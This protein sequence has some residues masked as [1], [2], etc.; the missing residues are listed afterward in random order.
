MKKFNIKKNKNNW[1]KNK[2]YENLNNNVINLININLKNLRDINNASNIFI[3]NSFKVGL[4][5]IKKNI[6]KVN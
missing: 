1:Y 6:K 4:E 5:L 3:N 2:S